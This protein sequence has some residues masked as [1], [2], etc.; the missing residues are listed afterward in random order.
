MIISLRL[1]GIP[2][3]GSSAILSYHYMYNWLPD[4][5]EYVD[6]PFNLHEDGLEKTERAVA[7][8]VKKLSNGEFKKYVFL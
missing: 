6:I 8:F 7:K 1:E 3:M 5:V 2:E 4:D